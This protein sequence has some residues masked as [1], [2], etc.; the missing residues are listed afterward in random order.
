MD[1]VPEYGEFTVTLAL[2]G[3]CAFVALVWW[4]KSRQKVTHRKLPDI[5]FETTTQYISFVRFGKLELAPD[6]RIDIYQWDD[7]DG[8]GSVLCRF[9]Y[10]KGETAEEKATNGFSEVIVINRP[11]PFQAKT[12]IID[13]VPY[14]KIKKLLEQ[15]AN[16][17][18][19]DDTLD[20][21][22]NYSLKHAPDGLFLHLLGHVSRYTAS[23]AEAKR[24]IVR[25]Q[26]HTLFSTPVE[27]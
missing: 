8:E 3:I 16:D 25:D 7:L 21:V 19:D 24:Y 14:G 2:I 27:A 22:Y 20:F 23:G 4:L 10:G 17:M 12:V 15:A 9:N 6:E 18:A 11:K 5:M 26:W 13:H 1:Y